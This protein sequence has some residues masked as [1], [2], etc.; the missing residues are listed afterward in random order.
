MLMN[1]CSGKLKEHIRLVGV[2]YLCLTLWGCG[3]DGSANTTSSEPDENQYIITVIDGYLG[4]AE[5]YADLNEDGLAT[6]DELLGTT[7]E[8]GQL[9]LLAADAPDSSLIARVIAGVSTDSDR[10]GVV[11][12]SYYLSATAGETI[13]SPYSTLAMESDYSLDALADYL[14]L[15]ANYTESDYV[16]LKSDGN[17]N[18]AIK[19]H[20]VARSVATYIAQNGSVDL[21]AAL[22]I[23]ESVNSYLNDHSYEEL[24][25]VTLILNEG[26]TIIV[27]NYATLSAYLLAADAWY[28]N[29]LNP[30]SYLSDG[31]TSIEFDGDEETMSLFDADGNLLETRDYLFDDNVLISTGSHTDNILLALP[32]I[33]IVKSSDNNQLQLWS[34]ASIG[35]P[36]ETELMTSTDVAG[37]TWYLLSDGSTAAASELNL[38]TLTFSALDNEIT[39]DVSSV[40]TAGNEISGSYYVTTINHDELGVTAPLYLQWDDGTTQSFVMLQDNYGVRI[41]YDLSAGQFALMMK[42]DTLA[43]YL[44]AD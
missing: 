20:A 18:R 11:S 44:L 15:N 19:I 31:E 3:S 35:Y 21:S 14:D 37:T 39:G 42:S 33:A 30:T 27:N 40:N 1:G 41:L 12:Q 2:G 38:T 9:T 24:D 16:A 43:S 28:I 29:S 25:G 23:V 13:L 4:N 36:F 7:D 10:V 22:S 8:A 17:E 26:E 5:V 32:D 6:E 34:A